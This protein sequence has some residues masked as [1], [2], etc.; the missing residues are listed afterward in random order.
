MNPSSI[1]HSF[2]AFLRLYNIFPRNRLISAYLTKLVFR[3]CIRSLCDFLQGHLGRTGLYSA[4]CKAVNVYA[5]SV[6]CL[7]KMLLRLRA[8]SFLDKHRQLIRVISGVT[9]VVTL[10]IILVQP[11]INKG[12]PDIMQGSIYMPGCVL[13]GKL[14]MCIIFEAVHFFAQKSALIGNDYK[15]STKLNNSVDALIV[16]VKHLCQEHDIAELFRR[17][18]F[19]NI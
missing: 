12:I 9:L 6:R 17:H 16:F 15:R 19:E 2:D 5:S 18:L 14:Q 13:A 8:D 10:R 3:Y 1:I 11:A 4:V 7:G